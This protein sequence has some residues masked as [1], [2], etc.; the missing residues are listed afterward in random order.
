MVDG[1][2]NK[3]SMADI[4]T[5]SN[6]LNFKISQLSEL[7]HTTILKISSFFFLTKTYVIQKHFHLVWA[8]ITH[9]VGSRHNAWDTCFL[10][11]NSL[12]EQ[13]N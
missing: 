4:S 13:K 12:S 10:F 7:P 9:T 8:C 2:A 5:S 11:K 1:K 6:I 3:S